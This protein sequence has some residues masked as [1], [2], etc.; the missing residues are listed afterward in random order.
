[1]AYTTTYNGIPV[2][3]NIDPSTTPGPGTYTMTIAFSVPVVNLI[4]EYGLDALVSADRFINTITGQYSTSITNYSARPSG[5][6]LIITFDATSPPVLV[7]IAVIIGL[8]IIALYF[9]SGIVA[10]VAALIKPIS[11]GLDVL[12]VG[13]GAAVILGVGMVAYSYYKEPKVRSGITKRIAHAV[14]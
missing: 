6:N 3:S 10:N 9:I 11:G 13:V 5:N 7:V 12:L 4:A 8:L 1:M 2:T 14:A